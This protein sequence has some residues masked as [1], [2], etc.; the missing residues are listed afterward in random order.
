MVYLLI[1][2]DGS[3]TDTVGTEAG[4]EQY[5]RIDGSRVTRLTVPFGPMPASSAR[6]DRIF[7]SATDSYE[8]REFGPYGAATRVIRRRVKPQAFTEAHFRAIADQFPQMATALT[9]IPRP[10]QAPVFAA[11]LMDRQNNLWVQDYA[12]PGATSISWTVFDLQGRMLGPVVLSANFRP[13]D[14]GID[15]ILGVWAEEFG[16][17]RVRMYPLRKP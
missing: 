16:V 1:S 4:G 7:L 10:S 9:G 15:Y 12:S 13:T 5:Q 6:G 17:E 2:P 8:I 3:T 14:I 11:L